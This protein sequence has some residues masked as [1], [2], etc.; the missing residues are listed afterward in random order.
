MR[1]IGA[2]NNYL[3]NQSR[4]YLSRAILSFLLFS[5]ILILTGYHVIFQT[6]NIG[7]IDG[8]GFVIAII[9][10]LVFQYY[11]RKYYTYKGGRQG[12]KAV[13]NALTNSLSDEYYLINGA[14]LNGRG[15]DIDHIVLGPSGI[16]VLETKNWSG[17]IICYGDQWQ[18]PGKKVKNSP[19][20]QV[21]HNTQKVKK[22]V[23]ASPAF[24]GFKVWVEGLLVFTNTYA[25]LC[26]SNPTV[27]VLK[28]QQLH[29]YIKNQ[30]N[31]HLTKEQ[32][33]KIVNQIQNV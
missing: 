22:I 13:I 14:Y 16:Y 21:K 17:K 24:R 15:G 7:L 19:S 23:D 30:K 26:L 9:W 28:L 12:E 5:V 20:L 6:Q 29:S 33:Q 10:L 18:R 8:I 2:A 25:D 27:T 11:Q 31:N 4:K 1:K 32:I 3:K